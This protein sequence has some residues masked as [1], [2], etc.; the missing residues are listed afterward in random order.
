MPQRRPAS[1]I[2][3]SECEREERLMKKK[4]KK[5]KMRHARFWVEK[6]MY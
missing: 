4:K 3:G 6:C 5:K 1:E 2:R